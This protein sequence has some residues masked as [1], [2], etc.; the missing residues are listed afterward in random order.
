MML[1]TTIT[2]A[3]TI[4]RPGTVSPATSTSRSDSTAW[5]NVATNRPMAIW[6]GL[7]CRNV[8]TMRGENWPM[9]SCTTTIVIVSTS[10]AR[11]TIDSATVERIG[12]RHVR[13]SGPLARD[14]LVVARP[15]GGE[16]GRR[17]H[18]AGHHAHHRHEPQARANAAD[19]AGQVHSGG[20]TRLRRRTLPTSPRELCGS[21][22]RP[23]RCHG[24]RSTTRSRH[25]LTRQEPATRAPGT[26]VPR[27]SDAARHRAVASR[28]T[29][30]VS[31]SSC[32]RMGSA[33]APSAASRTSSRDRYSLSVRVACE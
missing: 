4:A 13:P 29:Y 5:A 17:E 14:D 11:L 28:R 9:A 30:P 3:T 33:Q 25:V 7:S 21:M 23:A 1:A 16:R 20:S 22:Q 24:P 18:D 10:V 6:L 19:L 32:R 26:D 15:V 2:K 27:V 31:T 8:C 12:D